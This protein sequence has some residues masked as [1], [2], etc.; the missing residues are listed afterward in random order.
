MFSKRIALNFSKSYL[1]V[2]SRQIRSAGEWYNCIAKVK[3]LGS[4]INR[5]MFL[6]IYFNLEYLILV[7]SSKS[8]NTKVSQKT[9]VYLLKPTH[10]STY[11]SVKNAGTI[12][13]V[14]RGGFGVFKIVRKTACAALG[15]IFQ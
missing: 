5:F 10:F 12:H 2:S 15:R 6:K 4:V 13:F 1:Q 3:D 7:Q 14:F 11:L 8:L 9:Y